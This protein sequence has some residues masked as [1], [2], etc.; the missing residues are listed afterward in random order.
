MGIGIISISISLQIYE[1]KQPPNKVVLSGLWPT[2]AKRK[3]QTAL[4]LL[5]LTHTSTM[6]Q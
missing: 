3:A 6:G 5:I 4:K 2:S 1:T